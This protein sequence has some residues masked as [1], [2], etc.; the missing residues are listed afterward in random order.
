M[1][2]ESLFTRKGDKSVA[3]RVAGDSIDSFTPHLAT[4]QTFQTGDA[5][6]NVLE[7]IDRPL[8]MILDRLCS[9]IAIA[10]WLKLCPRRMSISNIAIRVLNNTEKCSEFT[11]YAR[12]RICDIVI[13]L[14]NHIF[15]TYYALFTGVNPIDK[16][17]PGTAPSS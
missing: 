8:L 11:D 6:Q 3:E 16:T 1:L 17:S 15:Y 7:Q 4:L 13:W 10:L 5:K 2:C 12:S 9:I 14:S